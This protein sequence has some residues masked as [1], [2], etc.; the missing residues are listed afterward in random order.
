V[1][2][3]IEAWHRR[4]SFLSSGVA[5]TQGNAAST[6]VPFSRKAR[7]GP[8]VLVM[9][10]SVQLESYHE[11]AMNCCSFSEPKACLGRTGLGDSESERK[12]KHRTDLFRN[13][14]QFARSC[15]G[16]E[17]LDRLRQFSRDS[18]PPA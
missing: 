1:R 16:V 5:D 7:F 6:S 3:I 9:F 4:S 18:L 11:G 12:S 2:F 13:L 15:L 17:P 8:T 10:M 14:V